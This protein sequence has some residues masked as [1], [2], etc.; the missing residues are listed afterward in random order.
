MSLAIALLA[1]EAWRV[2]SDTTGSRDTT[3][4]RHRAGH[5]LWRRW[6]PAA[7]AAVVTIA[8]V[9]LVR[10]MVLGASVAHGASMAAV[11]IERMSAL[12]RI[13]AMLSLGPL[14][15]GLLAWPHGQN[16]H[17]GPSSFPTGS[18]AVVAVTLTIITLALA[19]TGAVRLAHRPKD[20]SKRDGRA[21]AAIGWLLLAFLPASNLFVATG[22]ILAERTLYTPSI[23]V[24]MLV[25]WGMDRAAIA[26][27][28]TQWIVSA[29]PKMA[30]A[31]IV[32]G[33]VGVVAV[34]ARFAA[35][36]QR[37][38]A[39]WRSHRALID[40]MIAADP[41]GYRGHYLLAL[42]L[43]R[44]Q[45]LDSI[46][47]EFAT[48][49]ALYAQD[50]QLNYDYARFLLERHRPAEAVLVAEELMDN[51]RMR[52]DADAIAVYLET[53]GQAF[54]TDSVLSA[55]SRLYR[56]GPHPTLALYLGLAH[57]AR[58]ERAAALA[59]YRAGLHLAPGDTVLAAHVA[60]LQ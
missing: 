36:A 21:L 20:H 38:S 60:S 26:I 22:Q 42:E 6:Q 15:F 48:A 18:R 28:Q 25:A 53:R 33:C 40:Q 46:A 44:G 34:C 41:R 39:V 37:G 32:L 1:A 13:R 57:E 19:I 35:L 55:A 5:A 17:Y 27:A 23:G 58:A 56:D 3:E 4:P 59:A 30:R 51:L 54:G 45:S 47:R 52:R 14:I 7:I 50:P 2:P 16:P 11:G 43:R 10:S 8:L 31:A 12:E 24:A 9:A 49:Y 29:P